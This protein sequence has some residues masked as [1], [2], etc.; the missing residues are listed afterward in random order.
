MPVFDPRRVP[1]L[2]IVVLAALCLG[3]CASY[4][5]APIDPAE[6]YDAWLALD[7]RTATTAVEEAFASPRAA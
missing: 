2:A 7:Q 3:G 4:E 1:M 5:P 6:R